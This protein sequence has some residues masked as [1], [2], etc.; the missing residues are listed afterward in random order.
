MWLAVFSLCCLFLSLFLPSEKKYKGSLALFC[1]F[2]F[3]HEIKTSSK[4][5]H[6][7]FKSVLKTT[8]P[9]L[10]SALDIKETICLAIWKINVLLVY[11]TIKVQSFHKCGYFGHPHQNSEFKKSQRQERYVNEI[12][13]TEYTS[14]IPVMNKHCY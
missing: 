10:K 2:C 13:C 3:M 12:G 6:Q 1:V 4:K 7:A 14:R 11:Y 8:W 9:F 5:H